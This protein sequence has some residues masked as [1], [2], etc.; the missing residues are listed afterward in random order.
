MKVLLVE[1]NLTIAKGLVYSFNQNNYEVTHTTTIKETTK[2]LE[3][4]KYDI[5]ILD[6]TLPDGNGFE[7]YKNI[8][9]YNIPTIFLTAKDDEETVVKGL[10]I[11]AEDYI[12]KPF[13]TKELLARIKDIR[14]SE[15]VLYR[16]VLDL[17]ATRD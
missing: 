15:K 12:T 5:I 3:N 13:S 11:G 2:K 6:I 9:R 8:K 14:S 4:E 16:Q 1:D 17:Y 7:L 10:N